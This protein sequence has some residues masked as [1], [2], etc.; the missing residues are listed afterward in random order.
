[1]K[2]CPFLSQSVWEEKEGKIFTRVIEV[3][4]RGERCFFWIQNTCTFID[5]TPFNILSTKITSSTE[6]GFSDLQGNFIILKG[7]LENLIKKVDE[8]KESISIE[9]ESFE[10]S[11]REIERVVLD[12][13][14]RIEEY[15][16]I[17]EE[18]KINS[19]YEKILFLFSR[20]EYELA[21]E[22]MRKIPE[23]K[24][25]LRFK[26]LEATILLK[27]GEKEKAKHIFEE[28]I[29]SG[30]S[31][32]EIYN[33]LGIIYY[34]E[35]NFERAIQTFEKGLQFSR[36]YPEILYNLGFAL[37]KSGELEKAFETWE[38]VL[39]IDPEFEEAREALRKYREGR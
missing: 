13:E 35:G 7:L 21:D 33:N 19:I 9:R 26:I 15:E 38:K 31:S 39:E 14:K 36:D 20:G 10:K 23:E 37:Y 24:K 28:L 17:V 16:K 11:L 4:C 2:M 30:I 18:I 25:D 29:E 22:E 34:E 3:P 6:K 1:M 8:I 12:F 5:R 27:K 32:K